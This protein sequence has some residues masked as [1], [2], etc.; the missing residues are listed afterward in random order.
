MVNPVVR[1]NRTLLVYRGV[2]DREA[3][4]RMNGRALR[5]LGANNGETR[6]RRGAGFVIDQSLRPA[7]HEEQ[8]AP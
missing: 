6:G 2:H 1:W 3:A 8:A 7:E 5:A 4:S